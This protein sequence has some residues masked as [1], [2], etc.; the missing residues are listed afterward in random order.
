MRVEGSVLSANG[1]PCA[2]A[3]LAA[4]RC[5]LRGG[6]VALFAITLAAALAQEVRAE[7]LPEA[8]V[9]T[10]QGN[11][12][13]N[14]ER[15]RLRGVN[16]GVPQALAAYRPQLLATLTGGVQQVR[17][18]FFDNT[19]QTTTLNT[20]TIGFTVTQTLF[21]G[22]KTANSV[23]QSEAQ[24]MSGREALRNTGQGVLLDAVTAYTN[25]IANQ[26]LVEAQRINVTF[27]RETL[28]T[29]KKRLEGGDVTPT[30]VAQAEARLSRGQADLN[31]AEV[32][33]AISQ[34]LYAQVIGAPP[35]RLVAPGSIERLLPRTREDALAI[36]RK[37]HPAILAAM[38]DIDVAQLGA[39]IAE[40][41]LLPT[42]SVQGSVQRQ[43][44]NDPT[45]S[46]KGN[47]I[48]S[49]LGT[50]NV[51]LYDGGLAASQI[52][53]A[54]EIAMQARI[55]LELIRNQTQTAVLSAWVTFEG[56]KVALA[57][58][59]A[60]VRAATIAL[61]GVQ[62]EA[63]AG[64]RTTLEVLNSQQDLTAARAQ[65]ICAQPDRLLAAS[66]PRGGVGRLHVKTLGLNTP[67]DA[68]EVHYLQVRDASH[69]LRTPAGQ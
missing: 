44:E 47:D 19:I 65:L 31:A 7:A 24:V 43:W 66:A 38:Y 57:A 58:A 45:L 50:A 61:A 51:P 13:L 49:L 60:E 3:A 62:K 42:L 41:S 40:S 26:S 29:T 46:A 68:P 33:L 1:R 23:R 16:E 6:C 27:L 35:G 53:Q 9:R 15:A 59:E 11:P 10:Y 14:A 28:A 63:Q 17:N 20:W 4:A 5:V 64:Q 56:A 67:D 25:V 52:R 22:F 32:G 48:A 55:V 69:G 37:E 21:N 34:A 12:Q 2:I 36:S 39:K 8:L 18:L 30:D 54:K